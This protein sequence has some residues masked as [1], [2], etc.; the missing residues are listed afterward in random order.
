MTSTLH[1]ARGNPRLGF[2]LAMTTVLL[3][4]L[5]A[6]ALKLLLVGGMDAYT[7]TWYRLA[8]SALLLG[9]IQARRGRLPSPAALSARNWGLLVLALLGLLGNYVLFS[10]A[11]NYIPPATAQLVIQLAPI[12]LVVG[13]LVVF[14]EAFSRPQWMG[15]GVLI[16]GLLLFFNDRLGALVRLSGVESVGVALVVVASVLWAAYA[17]AQKQLLVSLSSPNILLMIYIGATVLLFPMATPGQIA[18]LGGFELGLLVFGVFNTLAA[19][20]CFAEALV[21]WEASR[22]SAVISLT[23]L[24]TILAVYGILAIW[25]SAEVGAKLDALGLVGATLIVGGSMM[26]ALWRQAG[27]VEPLDLE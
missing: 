11:L 25:P 22:V 7:I 18:V 23:P 26:T 20:G 21:H 15:L 1:R 13:S 6:I 8:A 27:K 2:L 12:L 9:A 19:Y 5:L 14:R 4:G 17:L 3:W 10:I 24:V 16:A